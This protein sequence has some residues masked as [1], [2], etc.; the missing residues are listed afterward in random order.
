MNRIAKISFTTVSIVLFVLSIVFFIAGDKK[1]KKAIEIKDAVEAVNAITMQV[2]DD[3]EASMKIRPHTVVLLKPNEK[4]LWDIEDIKEFK[5]GEH[6]E[7]VEFLKR[8]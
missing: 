1:C 5:D 8:K 4:G 2:I 3:I 6:S 7:Y